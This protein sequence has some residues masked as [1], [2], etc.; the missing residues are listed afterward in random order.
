MDE[1]WVLHTLSN[2]GKETNVSPKALLMIF[3]KALLNLVV[4]T[5]IFFAVDLSGVHIPGKSGI[6]IVVP[7]VVAEHG[8]RNTKLVECLA[9]QTTFPQIIL[10]HVFLCILMDKSHKLKA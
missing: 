8:I 1:P 9:R 7:G 4:Q 3:F 10:D 5:V 6:K 2:Q